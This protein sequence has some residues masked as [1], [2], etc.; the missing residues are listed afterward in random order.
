[1]RGL[2]LVLIY[3]LP[4]TFYSQQTRLIKGVVTE[5]SQKEESALPNAVI[6][7]KDGKRSVLSD[8][9]GRFSIEVNA[10]FDTLITYLTSFKSDTS[11]IFPSDTF[12]RIELNNAVKLTEVEV[13][14]KGT[15][16]EMTMLNTLKLET[17]NERSLMKAACCN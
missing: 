7:T 14:Y 11:L 2:L 17:M 8:L 12:V 15:G 4:F 6:K 16:T 9:E 1:M 13:R 3:F 5:Q 10:A